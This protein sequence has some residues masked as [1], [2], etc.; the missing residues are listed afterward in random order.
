[1]E[2]AKSEHARSAKA[3]RA[4]GVLAPEHLQSL[5][6]G[7]GR[8]TFERNE[9]IVPQGRVSAFLYYIEEGRVISKQVSRSGQELHG[10]I[11]AQGEVFSWMFAF[12][13]SPSTSEYQAQTLVRARLIEV[14]KVE[15]FFRSDPLFAEKLVKILIERLEASY[16]MLHEYV[17]E[18]G[19]VRVAHLMGRLGRKYGDGANQARL[20]GFTQQD[21]ANFSG[22][23][24]A[25][26]NESLSHLE[27][28]GLLSLQ[29]GEIEVLDVQALLRFGLAP[30]S[31][32]P[33]LQTWPQPEV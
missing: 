8:A 22:L 31:G 18:D 7:S 33:P 30:K 24:R 14:G 4:G 32:P 11:F 21:I 5:L 28:S 1:M 9:C 3:P 16:L 6:E 25:R 10:R 29:R 20:K 27:K 15:D 23:S 2:E 17:T 19:L 13:R 26:A 12:R